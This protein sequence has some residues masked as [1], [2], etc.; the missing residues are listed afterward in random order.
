MTYTL[1]DPEV[2]KDEVFSC[3]RGCYQE[4]LLAGHEAWSGA[5]LRGKAR[6]YGREYA[7]S[8]ESLLDRIA[9]KGINVSFVRLKHGR[10]VLIVGELCNIDHPEVNRLIVKDI[11]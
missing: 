3:V 4:G 7:K 1:F 8:R 6:D 2:D 11:L 10:K 9:S 5:T